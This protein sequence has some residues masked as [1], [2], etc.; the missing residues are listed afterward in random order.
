MTESNGG[1]IRVEHLLS[2]LDSYYDRLYPVWPV[3]SRDELHI[4]LQ[5]PNDTEAYALATALS[6]VTAAQLNLRNENGEVVD[7]HILAEESEK[8]R[9]QLGYQTRPTKDILLSSF[10]LHISWAN[11][12]QVCKS[13][14]L[15]REAITFAQLLG[16]DD[17]QHYEDITSLES[18][19]HLRIY[20]LLFIT[21]R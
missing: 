9:L 12:G 8:A 14:I 2:Y 20:W 21:E 17:Y 10:F 15:L 13:T 4:R 1:K 5:N 16:L 3:V 19:L 18:Q 7:I 6:A 11:R